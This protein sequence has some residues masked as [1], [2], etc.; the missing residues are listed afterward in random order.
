[1]YDVI[2]IGSGPAG[3]VSAMYTARLRLKNLVLQDLNLP[4][5]ILFT[6]KIE[7][8][9]GFPESITPAELLD[10]FKKQ[11]QNFG[12]SFSKEEVIR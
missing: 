10:R 7:N 4:S 5:Q 1:M 3:L 2:I 12:A 11:A 6:E 9:P 8:F